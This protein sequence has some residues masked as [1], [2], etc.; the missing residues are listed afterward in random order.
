MPCPVSAGGCLPDQ[1]R[2]GVG[3]FW[4]GRPGEGTTAGDDLSAA[5]GDEVERGELLEDADGVGG[6]EDGDGAG[7]ADIFGE[8]GGGGEDDGGSG[9]E[10]LGAVV[11]A[12]AED[13][14]AELVREGDLFEQIAET[15]GRRD[16]D[17]GG[18]I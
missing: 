13:I 11:L 17:A 16:G 12:D 18:G 7:E 4:G 15:I 2:W 3:G 1:G 14:E 8:R 6:G 9:V 5:A 10:V